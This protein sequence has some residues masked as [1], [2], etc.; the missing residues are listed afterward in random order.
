MLVGAQANADIRGS[1]INSD[2]ER[3]ISLIRSVNDA[4]DR[5]NRHTSAMGYFSDAPTEGAKAG[6]VSPISNNMQ[7]A[8]ADLDRALD[9]LHASLSLFD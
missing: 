2:V 5:V 1:R 7:T 9:G 4:R 3:I 8:L 6:S